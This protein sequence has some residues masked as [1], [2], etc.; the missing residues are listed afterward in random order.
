MPRQ[1]YRPRVHAFMSITCG[2]DYSQLLF[3]KERGIH[4][5][6][7]KRYIRAR[8]YIHN[9]VI[10][11]TDIHDGAVRTDNTWHPSIS[12]YDNRKG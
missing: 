12:S 11:H 5:K 4:G 9:H 8:M 1:V 10:M 3:R 2:Y 7:R 6:E